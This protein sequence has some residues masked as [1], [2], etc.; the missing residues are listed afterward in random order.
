MNISTQSVTDG[1]SSFFNKA[2]NVAKEAWATVKDDFNRFKDGEIEA[3]ELLTLG[4]GGLGG[5]AIGGLFGGGI[6][7]TAFAGALGIM[8][9]SYI[10]DRYL[11]K[12]E[13]AVPAQTSAA[14]R[15]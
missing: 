10:Q 11:E 7:G 2:V 8:A 13:Q 4:A 9:A 6:L 14:P 5:I 3:K 15:P 1:I 12:P